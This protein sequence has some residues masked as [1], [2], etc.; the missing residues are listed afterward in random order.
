MPKNSVHSESHRLF[1]SILFTSACTGKGSGRLVPS[2]RNQIRQSRSQKGA[3]D[4]WGRR[5]VSSTPVHLQRHQGFGVRQRW[6]HRFHDQLPLLPVPVVSLGKCPRRG[7]LAVATV[8]R[9]AKGGA[10]TCEGK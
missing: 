2:D 9:V 5:F 6:W 8:A 1:E 7:T 3:R 10:T 4:G